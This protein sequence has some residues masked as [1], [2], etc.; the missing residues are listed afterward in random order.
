MRFER[1]NSVGSTRLLIQALE[2][3]SVPA[4]FIVTTLDDSGTGSLREALTLSN[5]AADADTI[6]FQNGLAGSIKLNTS[7]SITNEIQILGPSTGNITL[8]GQKAISILA[9]LN[10]TV[11]IENLNFT[12]SI[13][14][15]VGAAIDISTGSTV[16]LNS[17]SIINNRS[18]NGAIQNAGILEINQG[19][20]SNNRD[21]AI[22]NTGRLTIR[23]SLFSSNLSQSTGGAIRNFGS[24]SVQNSTFVDNSSNSDGGAIFIGPLD[25]TDTIEIVNNTFIGNSSLDS[26]GGAIGT[27]FVPSS[28]PI[29]INSNT[30]YQ[31]H[32]SKVQVLNTP[33][34]GG[35]FID[36][37]L[38]LTMRNNIIA[39]NTR[40]SSKNEILDDIAGTVPVASSNL[41]AVGTGV[42]GVTNG[43]NNNQVGT[44]TT[45]IDPLL[46]LLA[47]NGGLTPTI[48]IQANSPARNRG[49]VAGLS[50][51]QRGIARPQ[52]ESA[53]IGSYEFTSKTAPR[54]QGF[55]VGSGSGGNREVI[56]YN[57]QGTERFR[58]NVFGEGFNQGV[59]V[60]TGDI[61]GDGVDDL[62][63]GS[64]PGGSSQLEVYDG[65]GS[66]ALLF[67]NRPFEAAFTGGI[68]VAVGDV[69]G[70]GKSDIVITPDEGG[71]PRVRIFSGSD[72]SQLAD[73]FGIDDPNFRG[74]ARAALGDIDRD[75]F[76]DLIVAAGFG[77]GPRIAGYGGKS[78][79]TTPE[80][81]FGDFFAF[82]QALRNGTFVALGD[83]NGDSYADVIAG[84]GPGGGPRVFAISG[85]D[86]DL[87]DG[88]TLTNVG[89][90]FVGDINNRGGVRVAVAKLDGD[91][92]A[93][94]ITGAGDRAGSAVTLINGNTVTADGLTSGPTTLDPFP[95]FANGVFVG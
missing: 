62:V 25:A 47:N 61:N 8:D 56:V 14:P 80:K 37:S 19:N 16:T 54:R 6:A 2:D 21:S 63:V 43:I 26:S 5:A 59:R 58:V 29:T 72:F 73:F 42:I 31:N 13:S 32:A 53:D 41:I 17:L 88:V 35:I 18:S 87:S 45:P 11:L 86:L 94:I 82:E 38:N 89:N 24:L 79:T 22:L 36:G 70:D 60:A 65:A 91:N 90:F 20:L 64:G 39:G 46:G 9:I 51:D 27:R 93:D 84:G 92:R 3:R 95:G 33:Q 4:V 30:I 55:A 57:A 15:M 48:A 83:V 7:L 85:R 1:K 66:H 77:G 75:G 69:N 81:L 71:G 74:G 52:E 44:T 78:L 50:T 10:S 23:D 28:I 76:D 67:S 68:Y 12:Q 40:G 49:E 34:G